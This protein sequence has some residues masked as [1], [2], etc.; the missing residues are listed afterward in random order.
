MTE[1]RRN[2]MQFIE[3]EDIVYDLIHANFFM[4]ALVAMELKEIMDIPYVV[5]YHALGKV[6]RIHQKEA[7]KFPIERL[8]IE[9]ETTT[10]A[11]RII[12]E[13]QQ[14]KEDL[15]NLYDVDT[16]K[17]S[18]VPCGF[19]PSE[20][21]PVN[22]SFARNYLGLDQDENILLQLGRMVPR[23]GVDTVI[24]ALSF[25]RSSKQKARF[26]IVGGESKK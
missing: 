22:Q 25:L 9:E 11:D 16:T 3:E 2:M 1:F 26:L 4:S 7:D 18:I 5:T 12:A 20:F 13:C 17:L 24:Q 14:D 8:N 23:K 21:Y 15:V 19:C 10:R 6:R